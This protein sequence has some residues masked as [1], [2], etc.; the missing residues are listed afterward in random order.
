MTERICRRCGGDLTEEARFCSK[1]GEIAIVASGAVLITPETL[2]PAKDKTEQAVLPY[3][4][5]TEEM[6]AIPTSQ[7]ES[8]D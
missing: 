3:A 2:P 8:S 5:P 6:P 7:N 1:C 4:A